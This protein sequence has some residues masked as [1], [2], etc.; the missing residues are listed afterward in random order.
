MQLYAK[1]W[2]IS[3]IFTGF[4]NSLKWP[5]KTVKNRWRMF[6]GRGDQNFLKK[7]FSSKNKSK[8][9]SISPTYSS[10]TLW[11]KL[12]SRNTISYNF[13]VVIEHNTRG[14]GTLFCIIPKSLYFL[15]VN[16]QP[17]KNNKVIIENITFL[18]K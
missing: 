7:F 16:N 2:K 9:R 13:P 4:E 17:I 18:A 3:S 12:F 5:N 10:G 1:E 11:S 15:L 6:E 14:S 8:Y